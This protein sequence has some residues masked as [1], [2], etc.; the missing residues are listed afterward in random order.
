MPDQLARQRSTTLLFYGCVLLLGYLLYQVFEPFLRPLAWA[1]IFAAFFYSRHKQLEDR[2]GRTVAASMSTAAVALIIVVPFVL[3]V[4]AFIEEATQTITSID[5]AAGS[6]RGLE[7]VQ[8]AWGW[9]QRQ[10][11][12][13]DIPDLEAVLKMGASRIAGFVGEGAGLLA[14]SIL[15]VIVNVIIMLFALFFFFRD[16]DKI[17][18]RLR[19]VLPF[20]PSFREGRIRE[21]A[22]LIKASISSGLIVALVQ[23][24]VGGL[25]FAMLGLGAPVFWGVTMAF[26]SLLPLGAWIVWLPVAIWLLLTGE[27]G[28]GVALLV[29]GA[30]GISLIDNFLRPMLLAGRTQMNGLLVFISLLGGIGAFGLIGLVLG[31]VIIAT[32]ISFVDA[33]ATERRELTVTDDLS[34]ESDRRGKA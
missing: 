26:F 3:V 13:R 28:R 9:L 5:L 29:M 21:T 7:R 32:A 19:R 4:M 30:A 34:P 6:S 25:T 16:G 33:Y 20:D 8:R 17:M 2:F 11:F 14:R 1:A 31:P 18:S 22:E 27:V 10:R 12:G 15:Y 24:A 23:G